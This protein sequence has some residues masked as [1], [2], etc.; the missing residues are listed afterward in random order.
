MNS[1][2]KLITENKHKGIG[3]FQKLSEYRISELHAWHGAKLHATKK[4][5]QQKKPKKLF[6]P[7]YRNLYHMEGKAPT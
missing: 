7:Q 6:P 3:A 4:T 5:N 1:N 2:T